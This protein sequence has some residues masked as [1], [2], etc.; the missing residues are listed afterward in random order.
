MHG[1]SDRNW[2][3]RYTGSVKG[4]PERKTNVILWG[5]LKGMMPP[6]WGGEEREK[7]REREN[8]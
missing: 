5:A 4:K 6:D 2:R 8:R 7:E 3:S 1:K